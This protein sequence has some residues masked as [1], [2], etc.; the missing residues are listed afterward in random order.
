VQFM[1]PTDF[2]LQPKNGIEKNKV[3]LIILDGVGVAP[4]TVVEGDAVK[5]AHLPILKGLWKTEPTLKLQ[6][7]G[8]AVG[9]PSDEDMGNSEV[10][11]NVLGCGRIYDQGA[12]LVTRSIRE[13]TLFQ[14]LV[15]KKL[16]QNVL[17]NNSTFH[18][19]GLT[20]DGNVHSHIDHLYKLIENSVKQGIKRI[21]IHTLLDGRDVP[22]KSALEYITPLEAYLKQLSDSGV[23]IQI[24]SGGG[25]MY[26]TMD[27]Y[28][29][30]WSMVERGWK[31]HVLGIGR[32]FSSAS[33]AIQ[34]FRS[35]DP[36]LT[37]QYIPAFVIGENGEPIGRIV[38]GDSVVFFNFRGDRAIEISR[39]FTE[40]EFKYFDRIQFPKIEYAGIMQYD[41]DLMI[42]PQYLVDPPAIERTLSEYLVNTGLKQYAISETQKFGHVTYFWNGNRSGYFNR[43]L[44][45]Y[46]EIKSDIV[47][48]DQKP[49]M[50]AVEITEVLIQVLRENQYDFYRVNYAN[51]D[52]VGHTGNMEATIRAL[53]TLDPCIGK[54][55]DECQRI[56]IIVLITADHGNADEM[57][58]LDQNGKPILDH[59]GNPIP[60]TSHTLNPVYLCIVDPQKRFHLN[61]NLAVNGRPGLAN[62]AGTIL[63]LLGYYPPQDY[64]LSL[65]ERS[66]KIESLKR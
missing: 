36:N 39:A 18:F 45:T 20:S 42:P 38:D 34:T 17:N 53:E 51:G 37:D 46:V 1:N 10:G 61:P 66:E 54:L 27:R 57:Y 55:V 65:L 58:Q 12:K 16:V 21:R 62:V 29:A 9:M 63:D 13:G 6:A 44:E 22:E 23:D 33:S 15:W 14:G 30:D 31:A 35:E 4:D 60:K 50:K 7:H 28:E 3:L 41:G 24:A 2:K 32:Q 64:H 49:E 5:K 43:N 40:S 48:F 56:G 8:T 19:I 25:R 47:P 26:M 52:M 11:H 59:S